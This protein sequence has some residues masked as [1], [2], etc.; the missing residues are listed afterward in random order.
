MTF[1]PA[2]LSVQKP[3]WFFGGEEEEE[4]A[5]VSQTQGGV[6]WWYPSDVLAGRIG[7]ERA[8]SKR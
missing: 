1:D 2:G 7:G 5:R 3:L 8:V 6:R 4:L